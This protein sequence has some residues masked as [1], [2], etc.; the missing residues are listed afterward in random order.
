MAHICSHSSLSLELIFWQPYSSHLCRIERGHFRAPIA[1]LSP[2]AEEIAT[3]H[4]VE[5][6]VEEPF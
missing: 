6:I 2:M 4:E 5:R 1:M 3:I